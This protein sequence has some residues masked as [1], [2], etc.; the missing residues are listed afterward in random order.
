[1]VFVSYSYNVRHRGGCRA[2]E[3]WRIAAMGC[4][5]SEYKQLAGMLTFKAHVLDFSTQNLVLAALYYAESR[6]RRLL[7][8]CLSAMFAVG[9]MTAAV[10]YGGESALTHPMHA[11]LTWI[12]RPQQC[13]RGVENASREG[14]E[15]RHRGCGMQRKR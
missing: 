10:V 4:E 12:G 7:A 1:M 13:S 5:N 14:R 11:V 8:T 9:C 3:S 2:P 6:P 15:R